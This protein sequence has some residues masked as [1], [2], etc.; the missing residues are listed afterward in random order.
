MN[1]MTILD[2]LLGALDKAATYNKHDVDPPRVILWTDGGRHWDGVAG[3]IQAVRPGFFRLDETGNSGFSGTSAWI[4]YQLGLWSQEEVVPIVYL[5]GIERHA[6][7]GAAGFPEEA[8]HLYALQFVGVFF[9]HPNSR[10]WTPNAF[11]TSKEA[12][13]ELDLA[14]DKATHEAL[15]SQLAQVLRAPNA[16]LRGRRIEASD[17]HN[18][19]VGD[20]TQMLLQWMSNPTE[21]MKTW[22]AEQKTAFQSLAKSEFGFDVA[23]EGALIAAER[24]ISGEGKWKQVWDRFEEAPTSYHGL[25]ATLESVQP[26][27]LFGSTDIRIPSVNRKMEGDLRDALHA[28]STMHPNDAKPRLIELAAAHK[29]RA[30]SVWS[31]TGGASL[32]LAVQHLG[33]M[34]G[35]MSQGI[36]GTSY[37]TLADSYRS[38]G[39]VVDAEARKAWAILRTTEDQQA[40][41]AAL[42]AS[43]LTWLED[44]ATRLQ[45]MSD[46]YP[47]KAARDTPI[48]EPAAGRMLLF[49]DG[50]R[51]DLARELADRLES[52]S[53]SVSESV[54][55]SPLPT[56]TATA[57][58]G[59]NHMA[60]KLTGANSSEKFEPQVEATGRPC[61]TVEFRKL[62]GDLGW[63]WVDAN[64]SG[65]SSSAGWSEVAS[66]D[67][68]GHSQGARLVKM[69]EEELFSIEQRIDALLKAGWKEVLLITD[70]GWLWMPGGLPKIDLPR[71]LTESKWGRCAWPDARAT[72]TLPLV[73]WFWGNEH[74]VVLAPGVGVFIKGQEYTHGGLSLQECL[75]LTLSITA[76]DAEGRSEAVSIKS[77]KWSGL[78]LQVDTSCLDAGIRIDVR[79]K[80][81]DPASSLLTEAQRKKA[82]TYDGKFSIFIEDD[83]QDGQTA[84][85]VILRGTNVVAKKPITIGEN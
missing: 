14:S 66:I 52:R 34:A 9:T 83:S 11:L 45:Q 21:T 31:K 33:K 72:H 76:D 29:N 71:H 44:Q 65:D 30:E 43:Y 35:A 80:P 67:K 74:H 23:A 36:D 17:I 4:R 64:E 24:L 19:S 82:P 77:V 61:T 57:K 32:A 10:D 85:L 15:Q 38:H 27:D 47:V 40:V 25:Q 73:P 54:R 62:L 12:S 28:L 75:T 41:T 48:Y 70:H 79:T 8:R 50:L 68:Q 5:P 22:S 53:Y 51:A 6:F 55:W 46:S 16:S 60:S 63:K 2:H 3:M 26:D 13:L 42:S 59:W 78:K 69:L 49:A 81:A 7:R 84:M 58:P 18:L 39:W 56:V 37:E 20:P 1:H